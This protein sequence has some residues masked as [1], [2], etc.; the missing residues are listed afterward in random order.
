MMEKIS[1]VVQGPVV[2]NPQNE[3]GIYSTV[4]VL[5]SIR[6]YYPEA[7][8]VLSTWKGTD[9]SGL[10]YDQLVLSEDP[11]GFKLGGLTMN[12]N[13]LILS[14]KAGIEKA[15]NQYIVKTRT[16]IIFTGSNLYDQ[17]KYITQVKSE[18]GVFNKYVLSTIY[19]VRNPIKLNLV[20]HPSDIFL[21]GEK[22]DILSH[23]NVPIAPR[24]YYFNDNDTTKIVSEQYFFVH[25][26]FRK[27]NINYNIP[28]WGYINL[29][30]FLA[31][32]K[33]LFNNFM[34]FETTEMGI[35]FPDRLY[36][37]YRPGSNYSL[38]QARRLSKIYTE[39]PLYSQL[40]IFSRAV[41]YFVYHYMLYYPKIFWHHGIK[42]VLGRTKQYL[43]N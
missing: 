43:A 26:I 5:F 23:F 15:S 22:E 10:V 32:E 25:N 7:E 1:F 30:Y 9:M 13:R 20:F 2:T 17:L 38:T 11:G 29:N 3:K 28:K 39:Q 18:Y 36:S 35:E 19:Y 27:K 8:I 14:T 42:P 41:Q 4:E 33:Y 12:Y 21:V 34:F 31:S 6:K 40:V 16:D 24:E 37:V